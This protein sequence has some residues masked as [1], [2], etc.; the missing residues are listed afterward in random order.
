V[1]PVKLAIAGEMGGLR[2]IYKLRQR[3]AI[4]LWVDGDAANENGSGLATT[5]VLMGPASLSR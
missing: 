3:G 5:A 2:L 4:G 1:V